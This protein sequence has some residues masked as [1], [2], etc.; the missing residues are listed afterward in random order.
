[1]TIHDLC[2]QYDCEWLEDKG[3]FSR[4]TTSPEE[5]A[6]YCTVC[7][8]LDVDPYDYGCA[9]CADDAYDARHDRYN[10]ERDTEFYDRQ[11]GV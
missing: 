2:T 4:V 7:G 11:E 6:W 5:S 8:S 9:Q 3:Q 10:M 1:M